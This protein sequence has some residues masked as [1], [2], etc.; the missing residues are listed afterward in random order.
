MDVWSC[1][2]V[3]PRISGQAFIKP[4]EVINACRSVLSTDGTRSRTSW[5]E[6]ISGAP[7]HGVYGR[8]FSW[9]DGKFSSTL[10]VLRADPSA[11]LQSL[12][13]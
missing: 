7:L 4:S 5:E 2:L 9:K 11:T 8:L 3:C 1:V 6:E 12:H 13:V 10:A